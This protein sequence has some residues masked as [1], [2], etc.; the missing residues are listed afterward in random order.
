MILIVI[1]SSILTFRRTYDV[2][3]EPFTLDYEY[4][5]L[6]RYALALPAQSVVWILNFP[7]DEGFSDA[8]RIGQFVGSEVQFNNWPS[9]SHCDAPFGKGS[10]DYVY[11]GASCAAIVGTG[12]TKHEQRMGDCALIRSQLAADAVEEIDVPARKF[13]WHEFAKPTVRLGLYRVRDAAICAPGL[14]TRR[15]VP[16]SP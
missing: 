16:V 12:A 5:F 6:K 1:V 14:T 2:L 13:T 3:L 11:I 4:H 10:H 15:N 8:F 9:A 7:E